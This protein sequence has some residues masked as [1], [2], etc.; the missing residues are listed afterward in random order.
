[1]TK[2]IR[3]EWISRQLELDEY[4]DLVNVCSD[5]HET[6]KEAVDMALQKNDQLD[7]D[8]IILVKYYME[9]S[10]YDI[11]AAYTESAWCANNLSVSDEFEDGTLVP[12]YLLKEIQK[13]VKTWGGD[14]H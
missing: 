14:N 7:F 8:T 6:F 1:M 13:E 12:K 2:K 9:G 3:Y 10:W 11:V 4:G 5:G